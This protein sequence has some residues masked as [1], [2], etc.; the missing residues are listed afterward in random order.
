MKIFGGDWSKGDVIALVGVGAAVLAI[1][2][3]PKIFHWDAE[4]Q[5]TLT[6]TANANVQ[7]EPRKVRRTDMVKDLTSGPISFGCEQTLSVTTPVIPLGKNPQITEV[8]AVWVNT[9]NVKAQ[10]QVALRVV[11]PITHQLIG[12]KATGEITGYDFDWILGV[13][14]CRGGGHGELKIHA[15]WTEDG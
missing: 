1:P 2:G 9:S 3:M 6:G 12:I 7:L 8:N 15:A 10:N 4:N 5:A 11:D 14:N 13:R